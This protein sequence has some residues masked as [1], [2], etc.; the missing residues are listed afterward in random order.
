[1]KGLFPF[2]W[3]VSRKIGHLFGGCEVISHAALVCRAIEDCDSTKRKDKTVKC[4][5]GA[6]LDVV[7]EGSYRC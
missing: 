2:F 7:S 3:M 4:F 5:L 1:M 6:D